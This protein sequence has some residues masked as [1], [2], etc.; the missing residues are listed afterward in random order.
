MVENDIVICID[1]SSEVKYHETI[2]PTALT[3]N[4]AYKVITNHSYKG[5]NKTLSRISVYNTIDIIN[6]NQTEASYRVER[7]IPIQECRDKKINQVLNE[8]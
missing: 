2:N 7:F 4:K 1:N 8:K 5:V 3:M 6:D